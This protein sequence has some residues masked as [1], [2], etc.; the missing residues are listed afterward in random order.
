MAI[1]V[2]YPLFE[3]ALL[4]KFPHLLGASRRMKEEFGERW[5]SEF[6]SFLTASFGSQ[7]ELETAL[8]GYAAFALEAMK[9]Q[10][11][12]QKSRRYQSSSYDEAFSLVYSNET[13]MKTLYLPGILLSHYLWRHHYLQQGFFD[14]EFLPLVT[15]SGSKFCDVGVGTGFYS[16]RL[17][18]RTTLSGVG[19]DLNRYSLDYA[20]SLVHRAGF[21]DRYST[22]LG[23]I[24]DESNTAGF[25]VLVSVEVLEHL[26]DPLSFLISLRKSLVRGGVGFIAAAVNGE[27]ADHIYLYRSPGEVATQIELAGFKILRQ[28]ADEAYEPRFSDE[29]VPVNAAFIVENP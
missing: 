21:E 29:L 10:Q 1:S 14:R 22:F 15:A 20:S 7:T 5:V 9:L 13:Y 24:A 26:E 3:E 28:V 27:N 23:D 25:D 17:L 2:D 18:S 12:F 16:R 19:I 11:R 8:D 4:G 6:E